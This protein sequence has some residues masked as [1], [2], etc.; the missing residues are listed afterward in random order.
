MKL[1]RT[2]ASE[3]QLSCIPPPLRQTRGNPAW[4][5]VPRNN[6]NIETAT[7]AATLFISAGTKQWFSGFGLPRQCGDEVLR[8]LVTGYPPARGGGGIPQR[9][10]V[11][12][13]SPSAFHTIGEPDGQETRPASAAGCR[14][15]GLAFGRER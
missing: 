9:I 2:L 3:D 1:V 6:V 14:R 8:M 4:A 15:S 11:S 10:I 5:C 7:I 13:R 12:S